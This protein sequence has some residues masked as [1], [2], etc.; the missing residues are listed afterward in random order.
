MLDEAIDLLEHMIATPS[1]SRD[2]AAVATLIYER[3][4]AWGLEPHRHATI[5]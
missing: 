2:E 1:V 5:S 4:E 3:L